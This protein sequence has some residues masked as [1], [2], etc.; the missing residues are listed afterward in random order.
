MPERQSIAL[1]LSPPLA[2]GLQ[3]SVKDGQKGHEQ[4]DQQPGYRSNFLNLPDTYGIKFTSFFDI[5]QP[6]ILEPFKGVKFRVRSFDGF[7]RTGSLTLA[8]RT[9]ELL[10]L[11]HKVLLSFFQEMS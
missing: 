5:R 3:A 7:F 9:Q 10:Y 6:S 1:A 11:I 4:P 2:S 8:T